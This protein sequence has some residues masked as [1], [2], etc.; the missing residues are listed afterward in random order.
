MAERMVNLNGSMVPESQAGISVLPPVS[1][2]PGL[3]SPRG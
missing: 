1:V 2:A 3:A